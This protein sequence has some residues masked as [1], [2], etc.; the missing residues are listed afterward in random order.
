MP[1]Q[2]KYKE[3]PKE[4]RE[5]SIGSF[6]LSPATMEGHYLV[7]DLYWYFRQSLLGDTT[8]EEV[9]GTKK[10]EP[11][12]I[13]IPAGHIP[14]SKPGGVNSTVWE[15][16][17]DVTFKSRPQINPEAKVQ[18]LVSV[19][20]KSDTYNFEARLSGQKSRIAH[21]AVAPSLLR[22]FVFEGRFPYRDNQFFQ[23][24]IAEMA[25]QVTQAYDGNF[26]E[27]WNDGLKGLVLLW[28]AKFPGESFIPGKPTK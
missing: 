2:D 6:P 20:A 1:E 24:L 14:I 10:P 18:Q 26:D 12:K 9:F 11:P 13:V 28:N 21:G 5:A 19:N 7:C 25:G 16:I 22:A 15:K 8:I 27:L 3:I 17:L 4:M 23:W